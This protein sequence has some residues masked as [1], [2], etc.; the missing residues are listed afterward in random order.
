[1]EVFGSKVYWHTNKS[2]R[3]KV[4]PTK[5]EGIWVGRS[6]TVLGE[7]R[8][9]PLQWND[10]MKM[11]KIQ[12]AQDVKS[13]TIFN[14]NFTLR[15][16]SSKNQS[17]QG[18]KEFVD[19]MSQ[20]FKAR[21]VYEI[22]EII[23]HRIRGDDTEYNVWWLGYNK[24]DA[25]WEQSDYVANY[26]GI[27][28]IQQYNQKL[29]DAKHS[30]HKIP[31]ARLQKK[32]VR[33]TQMDELTITVMTAI[34]KLKLPG[35]IED[36]KK[37]YVE[38]W[39]KVLRKR[40]KPLSKQETERVFANEIIVRLVM[41]F[42]PKKN[43]R[44]KCRLV[45]RGDQ[46]PTHWFLN[47]DSP[48][49]LSSTLKTLIASG[50]INPNDDEVAIGDFEG[51]FLE[52]DCFTE[53]DRK[54][55]AVF[56]ANKYATTQAFQLTGGLYGQR[57]AGLRWW[58]TIEKWLKKKGF[59]Q[60]ENDVCAFYHPQTH[61]RL[62]IHVDDVLIRGE[63]NQIKLFWDTVKTDYPVKSWDYIEIGQPMTFLAMQI[64]KEIVNNTVYYTISQAANIL[65]FL[66]DEGMGTVTPASAPMPDRNELTSNRAGVTK[67]EHKWIRSCVGSLQYFATH[68]RYD[69][70]YELNRVAQ[71]IAEPT[72]GSIL[73]LKRIMAYLAGTVNKQLRVPRVNGTTWSIYSDSDHAGD[74]QINATRSVTGVMVLC[75]GMPTHWQS[76]KQPVSSIS[77]AAA[78]IYAMAE[79][80]RDTNLRFWIAEEMKVEVKWPM[81]ILVDNAAGVSF[82]KSTNPNSKFKGIFDMREEWVNE[83]RDKKKVTAVKVSTDKNIADMM[84]KCLSASVRNNLE[85]EVLRITNHLV[86]TRKVAL[87]I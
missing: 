32:S 71:T 58:K 77:S 85:K 10:Q 8:V 65:Q 59:I 76:R 41:R 13:A 30:D 72:K 37:A 74:R 46:E 36:W 87:N 39:E 73:A 15:K 24:K 83:L 20:Q 31:K 40:L 75:N 9:L 25:T 44:C 55:W 34:Q 52:A 7:H 18:L 48:T 29:V 79:T 17:G 60:S 47:T 21:E 11:W 82:Q 45:A 53:E 26:G 43:G 35:S 51:A 61:L 69:I 22:K 16:V 67:A 84:T 78:E 4:A 23:N 50:P 64:G 57:D 42:E 12:P 54:R 28:A 80:V 63:R 56:K 70:A 62:A 2:K 27:T 38:E 49:A 3:S 81:E 86:S 33:I 5:N 19:R 66:T 1:M 6:N 68:T 14:G